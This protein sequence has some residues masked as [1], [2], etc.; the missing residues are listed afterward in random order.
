VIRST[1]F[2]FFLIVGNEATFKDDTGE[3]S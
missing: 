3:E 1:M 2:W